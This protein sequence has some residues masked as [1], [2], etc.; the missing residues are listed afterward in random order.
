MYP[1]LADGDVYLGITA[2][3]RISHRYAKRAGLCSSPTTTVTAAATAGNQ[4]GQ[5]QSQH[6]YER[7][8]KVLGLHGSPPVLLIFDHISIQI[9]CEHGLL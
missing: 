6:P 7:F 3:R 5:Q 2:G 1:H 9:T 8:G 4:T